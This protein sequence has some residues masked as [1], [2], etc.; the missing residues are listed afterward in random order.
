MVV[1]QVAERD[2]SEAAIDAVLTSEL[3]ALILPPPLCES[4]EAVSRILKTGAVAVAMAPGSPSPLL[5]T[6]RIDNVAAARD[7]T[8]HLLALGHV[9]FGF[10]KGA[11]NQTVSRQRIAGF[12]EALALAGHDP[13]KALF[14][15]G[16]F[17]Y[18][19]GLTAAERLLARPDRPTAIFAANDEM[20][21]AALT[22]AH[23]LGLKVPGDLSV[24]GFDDTAIASAVWPAL[25]T[26]RQPIADMT[27]NAV[28]LAIQE[29]ERRRS[30]DSAPAQL[31][32]PH[33]VIVRDSSGQAPA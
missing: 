4:E 13:T 21:A 5:P 14:E 25:T 9:R 19:S 28:A 20:A 7:L 2:A 11:A 10:I 1:A 12:F 15:D 32:H 31:L 18:R 22:V 16:D 8:N 30:A 6:I 29:I 27:R 23:S 24:V 33:Q 17:T 26:V 3:T